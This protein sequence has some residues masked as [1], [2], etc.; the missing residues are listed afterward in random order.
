LTFWALA[1]TRRGPMT[2]VLLMNFFIGVNI[3]FL[4]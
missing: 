4:R 3:L 2:G 1:C